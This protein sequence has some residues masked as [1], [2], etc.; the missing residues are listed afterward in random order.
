MRFSVTLRMQNALF[1][2]VRFSSPAQTW[3]RLT[4]R[5]TLSPLPDGKAHSAC[6][7]HCVF[8]QKAQ[9]GPSG[10]GM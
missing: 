3:R 6:A 5:R 7:F 8:H 4:E 2:R 9:F 10:T 1:R